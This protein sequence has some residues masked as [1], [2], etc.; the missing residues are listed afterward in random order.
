MN[1]LGTISIILLFATSIVFYLWYGGEG[2]GFV[3][4]YNALSDKGF[5]GMLDWLVSSIDVY[6]L[7][8]SGFAALVGL[9]YGVR[10]AIMLFLLSTAISVL[11]LPFNV[12]NA[13]SLPTPIDMIVKTY[14]MLLLALAI[15]S[16]FSDREF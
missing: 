5:T 4:L 1:G 14:F 2:F 6:V 12:I 16:F 7:G 13:A 9:S 3:E 15:L 10:Y 8:A 11:L